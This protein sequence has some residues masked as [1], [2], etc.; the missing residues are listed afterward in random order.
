MNSNFGMQRLS[1][2]SL[3]PGSKEL[4]GTALL[5]QNLCCYP[6]DAATL[7][8]RHQHTVK[9]A[10]VNLH[11][12]LLSS[13][14]MLLKLEPQG[15]TST[16]GGHAFCSTMAKYKCQMKCAD[17]ACNAAQGEADVALQ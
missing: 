2:Q 16:C 8:S 14:L 11:L 4:Y 12:L 5:A 9:S 17:C 6:D 7:C 10:A 13:C 1:T 15:R 3:E